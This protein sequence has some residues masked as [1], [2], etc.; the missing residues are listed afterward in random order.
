QQLGVLQAFSTTVRAFSDG[1]I[2]CFDLFAELV[3]SALKPEDQ[4]RRIHWL[5]GV[6]TE[7]LQAK[8][9]VPVVAEAAGIEISKIEPGPT[10]VETELSP[11]PVP[12]TRQ[13]SNAAPPFPEVVPG[14]AALVQPVVIPA[15]LVELPEPVAELPEPGIV[16][17]RFA[18]EER[19]A[20]IE[21]PRALPFLRRISL[22]GSSRP[23][24][25]VVM[26][27]GSWEDGGHQGRS[28]Q[29]RNLAALGYGAVS[30]PGGSISRVLRQS[31]QSGE[32]RLGF[33]AAHGRGRR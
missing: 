7:V 30:A 15:A 4:D 23:G 5:S 8:A 29:Y 32:A 16:D 9:A 24:L 26:E 11:S 6:A 27:R 2:R 18:I 22:P 19:A 12:A 17:E 25:S 33:G 13:V 28:C 31:D 1:D 10:V 3:L 14:L 21:L 20:L